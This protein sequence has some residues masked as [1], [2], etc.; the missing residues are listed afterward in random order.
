MMHVTRVCLSSLSLHGCMLAPH[1][2]RALASGPRASM[3][4][5]EGKAFH[6]LGYNIGNQ[7]GEIRGFEPDAVDDILGGIRAALLEEPP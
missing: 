6:A 4:T 5:E 3:L 2:A 1:A 7:L